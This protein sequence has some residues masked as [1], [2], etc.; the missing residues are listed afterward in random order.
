MIVSISHLGR[1]LGKPNIV[2]TIT[3]S[4]TLIKLDDMIDAKASLKERDF[5]A[6]GK[7]ISS[8]WGEIE[9]ASM[10]GESVFSI[11]DCQ[12][13]VSAKRK[14]MPKSVDCFEKCSM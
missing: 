12:N 5:L 8:K 6:V 7:S 2:P 14:K 13:A 4:I 10:V 1:K 9:V 3:V 11:V